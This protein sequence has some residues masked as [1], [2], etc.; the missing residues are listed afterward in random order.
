[1]RVLIVGGVFARDEEY[2]RSINPTPE[3]TLEAGFRRRGVDVV[4]AQ[5][6]WSHSLRGIDL[7]HVH[8][9]AKSVPGLAACRIVRST[10]LVFTRHYNVDLTPPPLQAAALRLVE[11]TADACVALSHAEA[12]RLR[13]RVRGRVVV[14]RNGIVAPADPP[15]PVLPR[16]A[17]PWRLLFVGQLIPLKALD[18]LFRALAMIRQDISVCLRLVYH[19][20]EQLVQLQTLAGQL[21]I[22][23]IVTFV[24]SRDAA[25]MIEEY[26]RADMLLLPSL[27]ESLPSVISESLLA[28]KPVIASAVA[29][30]PEQVQDAGVLVAP[31]DDAALASAILR[32]TSDYAGYV[33]KTLARA[34]EVREEFSV[35]RMIDRHLD[36]YESLL[37]SNSTAERPASATRS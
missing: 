4:V 5:H 19:N 27:T 15:P 3:M 24:G 6:R 16:Q 29:G 23:D 25:G 33:A 35:E 34:R 1:M 26:R 20:S 22:D 14:I 28:H 18:V 10:P 13:Q 32:L 11:R 12:D 36:L 30:I 8:H 2:R 7:V 21:A 37:Q 9:L 17:G 31:G